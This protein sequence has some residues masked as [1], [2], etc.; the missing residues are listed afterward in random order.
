MWHALMEEK[1]AGFR[2]GNVKEREHLEDMDVD[3]RIMLQLVIN[4]QYGWTWT[5]LLWLRL[6]TSGW[7]L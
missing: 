6:G 1:C 3:G 2:W 7:M 4:R 5:G